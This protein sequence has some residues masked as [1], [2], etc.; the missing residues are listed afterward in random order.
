M[1]EKRK[2]VLTFFSIFSYAT[3]T[4]TSVL[5]KHLAVEHR[6]S[7]PGSNDA[8]IQKDVSEIV[9]HQK[10]LTEM[11]GRTETSHRD[12]RFF[13]AKEAVL[14]ICAALLPFQLVDHKG[15]QRFFSRTSSGYFLF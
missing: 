5:K 14:M 7:I 13:V 15:F 9:M 10:T 8:K 11:S 4:S 12:K 2:H 1:I 6:I 3:T